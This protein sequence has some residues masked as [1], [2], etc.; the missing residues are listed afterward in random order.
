MNG[1]L[2]G[3][4]GER[5]LEMGDALQED[6]LAE[7]LLGIFPPHHRR[8]HAGERREFIHHAADIADLADDGVGALVE[9]FLDRW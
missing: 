4:G 5:D 2:R 7:Q 8:R 9:D 3:L 6:G 1:V